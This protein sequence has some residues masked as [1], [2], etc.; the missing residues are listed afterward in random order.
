MAGEMAKNLALSA[1]Q[2]CAGS[3]APVHVTKAC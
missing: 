3:I 2:L 1:Q